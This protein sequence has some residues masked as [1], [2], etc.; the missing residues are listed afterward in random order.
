MEHQAQ[1]KEQD[2]LEKHSLPGTNQAGEGSDACENEDHE[3]KPGGLD[4]P[5][6]DQLE[7]HSLPGTNQA[8]KGSDACETSDPTR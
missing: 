1:R 6:Q 2:Q 3:G 4:G 7:K 8:G 5:R